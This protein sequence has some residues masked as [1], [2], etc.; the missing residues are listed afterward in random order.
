MI[1]NDL[2]LIFYKTIIQQRLTLVDGGNVE[3]IFFGRKATFL[4]Y[5]SRLIRLFDSLKKGNINQIKKNK[6]KK[7][8]FT[9]SFS[10]IY[11]SFVYF[12]LNLIIILSL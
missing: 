12:L 1:C 11:F 6:K 5:T 10:N 9:F 3:Q 8:F 2:I 4:S 7:S